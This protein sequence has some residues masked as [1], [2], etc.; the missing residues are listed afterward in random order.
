MFEKDKKSIHNN[1]EFNNFYCIIIKGDYMTYWIQTRDGKIYKA[2]SY[3]GTWK[4]VERGMPLGSK[5]YDPY[6]KRAVIGWNLYKSILARG[7]T[8]KRGG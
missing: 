7:Q 2:K 3:T 6:S 8:K 4:E 1:S 5:L